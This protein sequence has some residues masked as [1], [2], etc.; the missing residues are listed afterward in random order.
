MLPRFRTYHFAVQFYHAA[1]QIR[2]APHLRLQLLRAASSVVLN[3]SEGSAR[4]TEADRRRF[5]STAF[6]SIREC[7]SILD[8]IGV[9]DPE[10]KKLADTLAAHA[11]R[12]S[13][14]GVQKPNE[15]SET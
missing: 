1:D 9:V 14:G 2:C 13:R 6:G 11:Y 10:T 15:R 4:P 3:L 12:L 5:Y 8:L 7:Q